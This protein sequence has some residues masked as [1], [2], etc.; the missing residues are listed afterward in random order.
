VKVAAPPPP[1]GNPLPAGGGEPAKAY[2]AFDKAVAK[3]DMA[4]VKN[5]VSAEQRKSMDDADFK[6][7]FPLVQAM[8]PKTYK[9]VNGAVDGDTA[10]MNVTADNGGEHSTGTIT[11]TREGGMWKVQREEWTSKSE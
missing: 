4:A 8:A 1:K 7:M 11:M 5:G 3:G 10:T 9:Y 2:L 6:K